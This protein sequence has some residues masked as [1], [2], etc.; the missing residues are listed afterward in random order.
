MGFVENLAHPGG[1]ITGLSMA[2]ADLE[3]KRLELLKDAAP[4]T[5]K[6]MILYDPSM[7]RPAARTAVQEAARAV[8]LQSLLVEAADPSKYADSFAAAARD[9]VNGLACMASPFLNFQRKQLIALA[10]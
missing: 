3:S 6:V 9:G 4:A 10:A 8:G 2:G 1:N 7:G 5:A